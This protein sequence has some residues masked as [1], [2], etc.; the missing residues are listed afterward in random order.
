MTLCR[1]ETE[2]IIREATREVPVARL[3]GDETAPQAMALRREGKGKSRQ[4]CVVGWLNTK[5]ALLKAKL[6]STWR[7][8]LT[9]LSS[10]VTPHFRLH[11][12]RTQRRWPWR[13]MWRWEEK[14]PPP[15]QVV[16]FSLRSVSP[17]LGHAVSSLGKQWREVVEGG[18]LRVTSSLCQLKS[19]WPRANDL[20]SSS[21]GF[22]I[23]QMV[24][25]RLVITIPTSYSCWKNAYKSLTMILGK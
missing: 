16:G 21:L 23:C 17:T 6:K 7:V 10:L 11:K 22:T 25:L 20:T 19:V 2:Y 13:R 12:P 1:E 24:K 18:L 15:F 8:S 4:C 9:T 5:L 14:G 3:L